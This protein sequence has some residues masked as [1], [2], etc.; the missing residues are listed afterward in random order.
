MVVLRGRWSIRKTNG[1]T[2]LSAQTRYFD[3]KSNRQSSCGPSDRTYNLSLGNIRRLNIH[4]HHD[5]TRRT[6]CQGLDWSR[7]S[8]DPGLECNERSLS[9][10]IPSILT[11]VKRGKT[12]GLI[13]S[14]RCT[15]VQLYHTNAKETCQASASQ[16]QSTPSRT[17]AY[18]E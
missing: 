17:T 7:T 2:T 18:R 11:K 13:L 5:R 14:D 9:M 8:S 12:S 1:A 15:K 4:A 3:T 10:T 6:S 16:S